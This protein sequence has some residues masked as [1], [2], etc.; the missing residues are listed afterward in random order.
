[1]T[2]TE[3]S[4][5]INARSLLALT[6]SELDELF[7]RSP[8]GRIPAGET[9]GRALI[10]SRWGR[11]S[12]AF[13]WAVATVAWRGKV[14]DPSGERLVNRISPLDLRLV[15]A[16]VYRGASWADGKEAIVLDYARTS[17]VARS[18]RDEIREVAPGLYV[19]LVFWR[20]RKVLRFALEYGA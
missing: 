4:V 5:S 7:A 18:V 16:R 13:A 10:G 8:A 11:L 17:L 6:A 19:G 15:R 9:A 20:R 12:S 14:F 1:L 2:A 3:A